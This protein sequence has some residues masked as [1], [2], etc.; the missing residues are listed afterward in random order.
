[1]R[2]STFAILPLALAAALLSPAPSHAVSRDLDATIPTAGVASLRLVLAVGEIEVRGDGGTELRAELSVRCR[3]ASSCADKIE[4]VHLDSTRQGD[5]LIFTVRGYPTFLNSDNMQVDGVVH[6][7]AGLPLDIDMKV[8]KL[9]VNAMGSDVRVDMG[10]GEVKVNVAADGIGR[11]HLDSGVGDATLHSPSGRFE[12]RRSM[13][14]GS[15]LDWREGRGA[16]LVDVDLGVGEVT[17][18]LD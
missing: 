13:L 4:D 18:D 10:V 16:A 6:V 3:R 7:P 8:G 14:I 12:A 2:Q 9:G 11:V 15:K 1:M 5:R 17:V